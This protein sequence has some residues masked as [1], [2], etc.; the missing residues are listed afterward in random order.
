MLNILIQSIWPM[1]LALGLGW[2]FGRRMMPRF[3][4]YISQSIGYLIWLLLVSVGL[5]FG[6]V[7]ANPNAGMQ[8]VTIAF[9][10]ATLLS[11]LTFTFLLPFYSKLSDVKGPRS[12]KDLIAP[13]RACLLAILMVVIG[14]CLYAVLPQ[15]LLSFHF[16]EYLLYAVVFMIAAELST[17]RIGKISKRHLYVPVM[18]LLAWPIAAFA[19]QFFSSY[20]VATLMMLS[21]G[22][23]WFSLSGPLV[24]NIT[25]S[26]ELGGLA[27]LID[28]FREIISI[29]LL[30]LFGRRFSLSALGVCG[31][32]AMDST[33][34]FV[35]K[36]CTAV[37]VQIAVF[38]GFLLTV[39]AP[40]LIML[41]AS[42]R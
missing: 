29:I 19:M 38:S 28:L 31:A 13:V 37:D 3:A 33:L 22:L 25:Q 17:V 32:T 30:Y 16:S 20:D 4:S 6:S 24:A 39:L 40:F 42:L 5:Q 26:Q 12:F 7:L 8:L 18:A 1:V 35:K 15:Q 10:Y 9:G 27:L 21:G 23:G 14:V 11:V 2:F 34:P 41:C 36:N